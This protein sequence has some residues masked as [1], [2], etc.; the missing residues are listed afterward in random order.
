MTVKAVLFPH[1]P[2]EFTT[3]EDLRSWLAIDLKED[4][5]YYR[6]HEAPGLGQL[7]KGSIVFFVKD[8]II[9]GMAIVEEDIRK[10]KDEENTETKEYQQIVK[11]FPNSIWVFSRENC[12]SIEKFDKAANWGKL[13]PDSAYK[14]IDNLR[15]LLIL[16]NMAN[17]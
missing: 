3:P 6:L 4:N 1:S 9:V 12:V 17:H 13:R 10:I 15:Q 16:L 5:G 8:R 2:I 14:E 7:E 11:F